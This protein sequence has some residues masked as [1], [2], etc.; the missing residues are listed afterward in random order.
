[1]KILMNI[2]AATATYVGEPDSTEY[3]RLISDGKNRMKVRYEPFEVTDWYSKGYRST[4]ASNGY[5]ITLEVSADEYY[6]WIAQWSSDTLHRGDITLYGPFNTFDGEY[7]ETLSQLFNKYKDRV[8]RK[9]KSIDAVMTYL[10][11][12]YA[13]W[14]EE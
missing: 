5:E 4:V 2:K 3:G 6:Q 10:F 11:T 14:I 1:M 9:F 8:L 13:D 12:N 7:V